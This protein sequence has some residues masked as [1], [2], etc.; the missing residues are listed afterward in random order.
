MAR[1]TGEWTEY[2]KDWESPSRAHLQDSSE[3]QALQARALP[4][5]RQMRLHQL[6]AVPLW[7]ICCVCHPGGMPVWMKSTITNQTFKLKF[8]GWNSKVKQRRNLNSGLIF[9]KNAFESGDL[10]IDHLKCV[11]TVSLRWNSCS[12]D[13][14]VER[15]SG[16]TVV[17]A[18]KELL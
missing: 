16:G 5:A 14:L 6:K 12:S 1:V 3:L 4:S 11:Q 13:P 10:P 15:L 9:S 8:E 18:R 2:Q 17:Q 7:I